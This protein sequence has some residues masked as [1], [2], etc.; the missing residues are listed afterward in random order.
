PFAAVLSGDALWNADIRGRTFADSER[1]LRRTGCL[2]WKAFA[3]ACVFAALLLVAALGLVAIK[4]TTGVLHSGIHSRA[5]QV[6]A[7]Q[8][9]ADFAS[10]L[11]S[12]TERVMKPFSMLATANAGRPE[13][14]IFEKVNSTAWNVLHIEGIAQ[15]SD[16]VQ[17]YI[18]DLGK[19]PSIREVKTNRTASTG[20]RASF[21]IEITFNP[22]ED[23][24]AE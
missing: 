19:N 6:E 2:A 17:S 22:L 8:D 18:E 20:G 3:A 12:V 21:D 13:G 15:R 24:A 4:I 10:N 16:L 1:R 14:V 9:K 23:L 5:T 11:E 7:L